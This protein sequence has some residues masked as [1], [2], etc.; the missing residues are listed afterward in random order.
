MNLLGLELL[1][2]IN[3]GAGSWG[4]R[5][6]KHSDSLDAHVDVASKSR[7]MSNSTAWEVS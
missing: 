6:S 3:I 5:L 7:K 4:R 2:K 1:K